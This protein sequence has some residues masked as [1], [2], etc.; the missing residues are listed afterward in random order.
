[1]WPAYDRCQTTATIL[2]E[3]LVLFA[4]KLVLDDVGPDPRLAAHAD[5][6]ATPFDV[7][8]PETKMWHVNR[9]VILFQ[10]DEKAFPHQETF[11]EQQK[12]TLYTMIRYLRAELDEIRRDSTLLWASRWMLSLMVDSR[13][14]GQERKRD[15]EADCWPLPEEPL[16][17]HTE[18][19]LNLWCYSR[20]NWDTDSGP[21]PSRGIPPATQADRAR[22]VEEL[23]TRTLERHRLRRREIERT[24]FGCPLVE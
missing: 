18:L 22:S 15:I 7:M 4:A 8:A 19:A 3:W 12:A 23:I 9:V 10:T 1:M 2:E 17:R 11:A 14:P 13:T 21:K 24:L 6:W 5:F 16:L 20:L